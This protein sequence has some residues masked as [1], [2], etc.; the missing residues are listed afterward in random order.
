MAHSIGD[1]CTGCTVC[2]KVCPTGA[3]SGSRGERHAIDPERCIDCGACGRSCPASA[4]ADEDGA[5]VARLPRK[6][7]KRPAFELGPCISCR[8][9]ARSC[10]TRCIDMSPPT[11]PGGS[12]SFPSLARPSACVSCGYCVDICPVSCIALASEAV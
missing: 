9:C 6:A 8:A 7:W 3:T 5:A 11:A 2:V 4:I 1:L 10:P 12:G